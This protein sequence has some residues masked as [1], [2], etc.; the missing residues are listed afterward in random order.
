M[1]FSMDYLQRILDGSS[2][3]RGYMDHFGPDE[4]A[5]IGN[6]M[7]R[8]CCYNRVD[9]AVMCIDRL[10]KHDP[11]VCEGF[12]DVMAGVGKMRGCSVRGYEHSDP[13]KVWRFLTGDLPKI[14]GAAEKALCGLSSGEGGRWVIRTWEGAMVPW[15]FDSFFTNPY[16]TFC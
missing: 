5:F 15:T 13:S 7:Y 16:K 2:A 10:H 1:T 9:Q 6:G 12:G 3:L 4:D 8:D 14:E 11:E